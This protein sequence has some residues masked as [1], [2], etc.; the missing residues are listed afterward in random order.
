[1]LREAVARYTAVAKEVPEDASTLR[2]LGLAYLKG[3][4]ADKATETFGH[5]VAVMPD[6]PEAHALL[7]RVL[8]VAQKNWAV[9]R[10]RPSRTS[11]GLDATR[12]RSAPRVRARA[13]AL[14]S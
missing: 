14:K 12:R 9:G 4:Q 10:R 6:D 11:L 2:S 13:G 1:M 3:A 8:H 7:A 5:L